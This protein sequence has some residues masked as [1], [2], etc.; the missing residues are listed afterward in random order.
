LSFR[1]RLRVF[2]TIIVIVPMIAVALV[3]FALTSESETGKA[4]AAIAAGLR[5]ALAAT[6]DA[7]A[8]AEPALRRVARDGPLNAELAGGQVARAGARMREVIRANPKIVS[9]ELLRPGGR[10]VRAGDA[11]GVAPAA[12]PLATQTGRP[13][14]T[15]SVSVTPAA[16]LARRVARLSGLEASVFEGG[17][18]LAS[19]VPGIPGMAELGRPDETRSFDAAGHD[20]RGRTGRI[21][22]AGGSPSLEV[23]VFERADALSDSI[24][25]SRLLIGAILA[26]FLV[27]ALASSVLVSRALQGQI[28]KFLAAA[29]RLAS[30]DFRQP[31]PVEGQDEFAKLGREFNS[32]SD[33]LESKIEEV[34]RKRRE[35]EDTIRRVGAALATGL[36]RQGVVELVVQTAV[37]ACEAEA[38][39]AQPVDFH[40]FRETTTGLRDDRVRAAMQ[41]AER[42]AFA[43]RSDVISELLEP[44][45]ASP[46]P[47]SAVAAAAEGAHA[48]A[49]PMLARLGG[50]LGRE[51]V[52]VVSIARRG[53][54]FTRQEEELLEYLAGQAVISIENADLHETVQQQAVTDELT[55]LANVRELHATLDRELERSRRFSS[56]MGFVMADIDDFKRVNDVYGHQQ[57]DEVL[58]QVASA[59]RDLSRDIDEPARYGGE[60]LAVVLPET[61]AEGTALLAERMREAIE[62]LRVPR[63]DGDGH[64]RVTA[65]FGVAS[66]PESAGD[67]Q[68]LIAAADEA[69]YRAKRSGKNRVERAHPAAVSR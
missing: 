16:E 51:Y 66:T 67:K 62:G 35:L 43:V 17:R 22:Q 39:R 48:R 68:G 30:G 46:L 47:H 65:S 56:P 14:G 10:S 32:M 9:I 24:T 50:S 61:D 18:R 29:R 40:V 58:V 21:R 8:R 20:Y 60:E 26:A 36:D 57:G 69:L 12:A 5:G 28:G 52:G 25:N 6:D 31:V 37:D 38:G 2:F 41:A 55:G 7:G 33:Q 59:L 13:V 15:L 4:D 19:T 49:V 42:E 23:V 11:G 34:E 3:L 27:L 44:G 45:E 53:H 1:G 54:D 64:L 63:I